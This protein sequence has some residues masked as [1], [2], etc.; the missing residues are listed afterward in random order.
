MTKSDTRRGAAGVSA[1]DRNGRG[2]RAQPN[3]D[4]ELPDGAEMEVT[5]YVGGD[6][7]DDSGA[8]AH[9]IATDRTVRPELVAL[10]RAAEG[11]V[12][13]CGPNGSSADHDE[14]N[15]AHQALADAL[16]ALRAALR[17]TGV[18]RG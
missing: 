12:W 2:W 6:S 9:L 17:E 1:G 4:I 13:H 10:V 3:G 18:G 11:A 15:R 16:D 5:A 14:D 7:L 8:R